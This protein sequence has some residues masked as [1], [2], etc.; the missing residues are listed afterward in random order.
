MMQPM[1]SS[2][3]R[4]RF[5]SLM[6]K[7]IA[8]LG[9][10]TF[11]LATA[12]EATASIPTSEGTHSN[13]IATQI[14]PRPSPGLDGLFLELPPLGD[15]DRFLPQPDPAWNVR[16]VISLSDRQVSVYHRDE[17]QRSFPIAIG[18]SGWE[19]PTGDFEVMQM[20]QDPFWENP[21][22]GEV[23]P[24]G[25]DN[26]L[27]SRWI[28]FW[29]DGR[30]YIGFHGTPNINSVGTAASHGC[31]RMYDHDVVQLFE[32]VRLGTPVTVVP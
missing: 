27:G 22:T 13:Q 31:I 28:G 26:P 23:I 30:N 10:M 14:P 15:P 19:T 16:L 6:P 1:F 21:F 9:V 24:P 25:A 32:L 3:V 11:P 7:A 8:I 29:T 5:S 2:N 20:I 18:R 4:Q 12:L 17:Y